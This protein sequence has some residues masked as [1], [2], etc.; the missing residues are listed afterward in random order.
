MHRAIISEYDIGDIHMTS[1]TDFL[2]DT[3]MVFKAVLE[4]IIMLVTI[5]CE[6]LGISDYFAIVYIVILLLLWWRP[7]K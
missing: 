7:W 1:L 2:R 4:W 3:T 6:I 5:P